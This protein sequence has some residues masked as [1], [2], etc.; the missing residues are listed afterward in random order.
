MLSKQE[1][2]EEGDEAEVSVDSDLGVAVW[3]RH[4]LL[5]LLLGL[6]RIEF[7]WAAFLVN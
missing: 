6:R 3:S 7:V 1:A 5:L 2:A 4:L